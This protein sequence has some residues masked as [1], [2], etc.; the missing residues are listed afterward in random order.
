[1]S[2][3]GR[4]KSMSNLAE[5]RAVSSFKNADL[6][7]EVELYIKTPAQFLNT[8]F[9]GSTASSIDRCVVL[10]RGNLNLKV[11]SDRAPVCAESKQTAL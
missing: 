3:E 2:S 8:G 10:P 11:Q 7:P 6:H 1:M 9:L 4:M 5:I